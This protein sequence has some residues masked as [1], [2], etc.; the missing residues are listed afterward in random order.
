MWIRKR[1]HELEKRGYMVYERP[2]PP[3]DIF[4]IYDC[5]DN[6]FKARYMYE[7]GDRQAAVF[8]SPTQAKGTTGTFT[9]DWKSNE[10][11]VGNTNGKPSSAAFAN[12]WR[13]LMA[14]HAPACLMYPKN[15]VK[16]GDFE[17][18][19]KAV[20]SA[21]H[22]Y[23]W[24]E[25]SVAFDNTVAKGNSFCLNHSS[26]TDYFVITLQQVNLPNG[27]YRLTFNVV[28]SGGQSEASARVRGYGGPDRK[29]ENFGTCEILFT[30]VAK[31]NQWLNIDDVVLESIATP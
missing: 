17:E 31:A 4:A 1:D 19:K 15:F 12:I 30:S 27:S 7:S 3:N 10:V 2:V 28:C 23:T 22:W 18:D 11:L 14:K 16:N 20:E 21:V 26:A 5:D 25:K 29:I 6:A 24:P 13:N 8:D 9:C